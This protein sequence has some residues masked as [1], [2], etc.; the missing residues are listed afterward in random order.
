MHYIAELC[1]KLSFT[2]CGLLV[3]VVAVWLKV[4]QWKIDCLRWKK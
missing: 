2:A 4:P 3:Y 1:C